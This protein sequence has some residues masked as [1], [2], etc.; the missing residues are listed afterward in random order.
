MDEFYIGIIGMV[1][2]GALALVAMGNSIDDI[3][4]LGQSICD[5]NF[6]GNFVRYSDGVLECEE[7]DVKSYDGLR[8]EVIG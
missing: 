7:V 8:V 6:N 2:I 1:V 3:R 4:E 5:E